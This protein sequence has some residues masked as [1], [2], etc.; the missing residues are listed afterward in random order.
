MTRQ[1]LKP[2]KASTLLW[3]WLSRFRQLV[4]VALAAS[5]ITLAVIIGVAR[6]VLPFASDYREQIQTWVSHYFASDLTFQTID[7]EWRALSPRLRLEGVRLQP[8]NNQAS[9]L[10]LN[11]LFINLDLWK[12]L[13]FDSIQIQ[14]ISLEGIHIE[15]ERTIDGDFTL[16]GFNLTAP[17]SHKE[18]TAPRNPG[19]AFLNTLFTTE[20]IQLNNASL[21]LTDH[22]ANAATYTIDDLDI[23]IQNQGDTHQVQAQLIL[24]PT[25]GGRI[26]AIAEF[27]GPPIQ[28][29]LWQGQFYFQGQNLQPKAWLKEVPTAPQMINRG[30]LNAEVWGRWE[31]QLT[32]L[33]VRTAINDLVLSTPA[34]LGR[35]GKNWTLD[36]LSGHALWERQ[37]SGWQLSVEDLRIHSQHGRRDPTSLTLSYQNLPDQALWAASIQHFFLQDTASLSLFLLPEIAEQYPGRLN[38]RLYRTLSR[39]LAL[40]PEG[41]I[42]NFDLALKPAAPTSDKLH[43]QADFTRINLDPSAK[44][45]GIKGLSGTAKIAGGQ[46]AIQLDTHRASLTFAKLF[47][48]PLPVTKATGDLLLDWNTETFT[49]SSRKLDVQNYDIST[50]TQLAMAFPPKGSPEIDLQTHFTQGDA[51][52]ASRYLP[53]SIMHPHLI[54][55]LD[56]SIIAGT[57]T[58]GAVLLKGPTRSFPFRDQAGVFDVTFDVENAH[59]KY[60]PDWPALTGVNA[61]LVFHNAGMAIQADTAFIQN[62]QARNI[63]AYIE[64]YRPAL[65]KIDGGINT[66]VPD[67]L[68]FI[69]QSPLKKQIG[70]FFTGTTGQGDA[71][72]TL[73]LDIPLKN[74]NN[75]QVAGNVTMGDAR[76][77]NTEKK[78]VID[79]I[80]GQIAFTHK[81]FSIDNLLAQFEGE[82]LTVNAAP[83]ARSGEKSTRLTLDTRLDIGKKLDEY[84]VQLGTYLE[85]GSNWSIDLFFPNTPSKKGSPQLEIVAKSDLFGLK[86]DLPEPFSKPNTQ[87]LPMV[88]T[89]TLEPGKISYWHA[90]L[91]QLLNAALAFRIHNNTPTIERGIIQFGAVEEVHL[92]EAKT[93]QITGKL[94]QIDLT[95]W[96]ALQN[97]QPSGKSTRPPLDTEVDLQFDQLNANWAQLD[98]GR[99]QMRQTANGLITVIDSPQLQGEVQLSNTLGRLS[100]VTATLDFVDLNALLSTGQAGEKVTLKQLAPDM[101]PPLNLRIKT[102]QWS[103]AILNNV[104]L[105]TSTQNQKIRLENIS[106]QN[107]H[108]RMRGTGQWWQTYISSGEVRDQTQ[109]ELTLQSGNLSRGLAQLGFPGV[110]DSGKGEI[111]TRTSWAGTPFSPDITHLDGKILVSLRDGTLTPVDP[112]PAK[113]LGLVALKELPRR[114]TLDFNNMASAGLP[115]DL[116]TGEILINQGVATAHDTRLTGP[117]AR[118]DLTGKTDLINRTYDQF[119]TVLPNIGA[120][121]PVVGAL[122]GGVVTGAIVFMADRIFKDLGVDIDQ[123][124]QVKYSLTGSWENPVLAPIAPETQEFED[125]VQ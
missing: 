77:E 19:V 79:E 75:T 53:V 101:I 104:R 1:D 48:T 57:I 74:M 52:Q 95:P 107:D 80:A 15:L 97:Q 29:S 63:T 26:T 38:D 3:R 122:A 49:L 50:S 12:S 9:P 121:L 46:A 5:I 112:G 68:D 125:T 11:E 117:V 106:F 18:V 47:R 2:S 76:L 88:L 115:F 71:Q 54:K 55:W 108:I 30:S 21:T 27:S 60:Q 73:D 34:T 35:S 7:I 67:L 82:A 31:H 59:L 105:L 70:A 41:E 120:S 25:Y 24:P 58:Q 42:R 64:D 62:S 96:M 81:T 89:G 22:T 61:H 16:Q 84:G 116:M 33:Q 6:L 14:D 23:A 118:V 28:P 78:L 86:V 94:T 45:P 32:S 4:L 109:L 124:G 91:D 100:P 85:G 119:I 113:I 13:A 111:Q 123:I 44:I 37:P 90:S 92:P 40:S 51:S 39:V 20:Q 102:L 10:V 83:V 103:N 56:E 93:L 87:T 8:L 69:D 17:P 98:K 72:V 36:N 99:L 43:L 65:L 110:L 66:T 114:L